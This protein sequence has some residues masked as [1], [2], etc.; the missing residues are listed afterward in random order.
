MYTDKTLDE[1]FELVEEKFSGE[2]PISHTKCDYELL[3]ELLRKM[4]EAIEELS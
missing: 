1:L 2:D 4:K 3:I